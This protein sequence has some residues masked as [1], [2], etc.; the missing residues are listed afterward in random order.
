MATE[1]V[2]NEVPGSDPFPVRKSL[3]QC[4]VGVDL[5]SIFFALLGKAFP[6][7]PELRA[8]QMG[9]TVPTDLCLRLS[10]LAIDAPWGAQSVRA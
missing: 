3:I 4:H 1:R 9:P 2:A 7:A 8:V 6:H 5:E 10:R